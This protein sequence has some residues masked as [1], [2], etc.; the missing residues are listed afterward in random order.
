MSIECSE[1]EGDARSS[2]SEDCKRGQKIKAR[3]LKEATKK[4]YFC[5][6]IKKCG[7]KG[8]GAETIERES[9][10]FMGDYTAPACPKCN[11]FVV[12]I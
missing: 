11:R 2:H 1:C 5:P 4:K 8:N 3:L 10:D 12:L 9:D 6:A 7:W